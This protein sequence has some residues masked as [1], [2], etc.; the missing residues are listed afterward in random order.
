[1]TTTMARSKSK[2]I[3]EGDVS[4]DMIEIFRNNRK[5]FDK[6]RLNE[7]AANIKTQGVLQPIIL[8]KWVRPGCAHDGKYWL[9]AG[10][11]RLRASKIAE[12]ES[13]PARVLDVTE[14]EAMEIQAFENLHRED[15]GPLEEAR[16]FK[17][18]MRNGK[19][20]AET[21]AHQVDKSVNFVYRAVQ[22]LELPEQIQERI[23]AGQLTPAHGHQVLRVP[24]ANRKSVI[25]LL[26]VSS[27]DRYA[28]TAK[29]LKDT[30]DREI[31]YPLSEGEFTKTM[32]YA[33]RISCSV[34]P[35]NSGNQGM[36]FDGNTKGRCMDKSCFDKKVDQYHVDLG[37]R[38]GNVWP[39][40][41]KLG[42]GEV[43][44]WPR[45]ISG[46]PGVIRLTQKETE[47][48]KIKKLFA[49]KPGKLG[50]AIV[51]RPGV[52]EYNRKEHPKT[53]AV[54]VHRDPP[55]IGGMHGKSL[56]PKTDTPKRKGGGKAVKETD[57]DRERV[58]SQAKREV[59]ENALAEKIKNV[60]IGKADLSRLV[61]AIYEMAED[62]S[63]LVNVFGK[64]LHDGKIN[65]GLS[66]E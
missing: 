45:Q 43:G 18:L 54:I 61:V 50:I 23:E 27:Y 52:H 9:I 21:L 14:D 51:K 33:N 24:K 42:V 39:G 47:T 31:G 10:E 7:L 8:R 26:A 40:L 65:I 62:S 56:S 22:L 6:D 1:M 41:E 57:W 55:A 38:L 28:I 2:V 30:V 35:Q 13:I 25:A 5:Y 32:N 15:L 37:E 44:G 11:R 16:A 48:P 34:C 60:K 3:F 29:E 49:S 20:T 12:L 46:V 64:G 53:V 19:H 4:I 58:I 36:L 63:L 17:T 59:V 66:L